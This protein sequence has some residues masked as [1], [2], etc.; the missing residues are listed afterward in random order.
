MLQTRKTLL[1]T[2]LMALTL[3]FAPRAAQAQTYTVLN[4]FGIIDQGFPGGQVTQGRDGNL[5]GITTNDGAIY[6]ITPAGVETLQVGSIGHFSNCYSGMILGTDGNFYGT[7]EVFDVN[8]NNNGGVFKFTPGTS[9]GT[10]TILANFSSPGQLPGPLMQAADG[11][12]YGATQLAGTFNAG[13]A[14][15]I[16]TAG[17][18]TTIHNFVGGPTEPAQP[19]PTAP[20]IQAKDGNLY[21]TA[22]NGCHANNSGCVFKMSTAGVVTIIADLNQTGNSSY[23]YA[24]VIQGSDGLF[25][26]ATQ[27]GNPV[28]ANDGT[29]YKVTAAGTYTLLHTFNETT[30]NGGFPTSALIQATDGN[31]YSTANGCYA[32]GCQSGNVFKVT[33][34]GVYTTLTALSPSPCTNNGCL[35]SGPVTQHTNGTFY[36]TTQQGGTF[37]H[38]VFF[39][40]TVSP[41]LAA[42]VSI[43]QKNGNVG[44]TVNVLGQGFNGATA[45]KFG[46]VAATSFTKV[47]DTFLTAIVPTGAITGKITVTEGATTLT[48]AQTYSVKAKLTSFTPSS[49]PVGTLVT[50][51]GT[52]LKQVSKVTFNNVTATSFTVVSDSKVTATV[53]TGATTGKIVVTNP[54]GTA[55]SATSFTV[56]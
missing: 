18:M 48:S 9:S 15:K 52:G 4:N 29:V 23:P 49:G 2:A 44:A 27:L 11:N 33:P 36:G 37:G 6:R 30:D 19:T 50:I 46:G 54:A 10:F 1:M 22:T 39:S 24:G 5:Y 41:A 32:G 20:L 28:G 35:P 12:L 55:T 13:T 8:T 45:V 17:V 56:N 53:P 40:Q 25:Y 43:Q 51:N 21:G 3:T 14:Y 42:F 38:G 47:S 16:T 31:F 26:G 34:R 7:C